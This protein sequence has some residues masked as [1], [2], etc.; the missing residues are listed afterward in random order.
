MIHSHSLSLSASYTLAYSWLVKEEKTCLLIHLF[1]FSQLS[2]Y[3]IFL[4]F[5]EYS[6]CWSLFLLFRKQKCIIQ[7]M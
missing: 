5:E 4:S 1:Y 7:L 2:Y 6:D 3:F